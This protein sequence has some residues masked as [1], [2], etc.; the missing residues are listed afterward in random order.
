MRMVLSDFASVPID[1]EEDR[2]G[3]KIACER[4]SRSRDLCPKWWCRAAAAKPESGVEGMLGT[5]S[6]GGEGDGKGADIH[7][8][9]REQLA[10]KRWS[11][12][13]KSRKVQRSGLIFC[14]RVLRPQRNRAGGLNERPA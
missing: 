12:P 14:L 8:L 11:F 6:R 5:A 10:P 2:T 3:V 9:A 7:T 4:P 13:R 1:V